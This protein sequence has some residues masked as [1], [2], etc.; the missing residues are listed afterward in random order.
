MDIGTISLIL[1]LGMI[2]LLAI[3]MPLGFA[4]AVLALMRSAVRTNQLARLRPSVI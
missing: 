4:S 1:V 3:G 2:V